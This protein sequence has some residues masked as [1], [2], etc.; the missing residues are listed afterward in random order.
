[1]QAPINYFSFSMG[2]HEFVL[3]EGSFIEASYYTGL[4]DLTGKCLFCLLFCIYFLPSSHFKIAWSD[5]SKGDLK[6]ICFARL[7]W[8][9][10]YV[11]ILMSF[12]SEVSLWSQKIPILY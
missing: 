5:Y 4:P 6:L 2:S 9:I 8:K 1:M 3:S 10:V 11:Q 12:N 7:R